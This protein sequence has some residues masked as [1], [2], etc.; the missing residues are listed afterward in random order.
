MAKVDIEIQPDWVENIEAKLQ[1]ALDRM[2]KAIR[3]NARAKAPMSE[4]YYG[5]PGGNLRNSGRVT[6]N[7]NIRLIS[8]GGD[9]VPYGKAQEFG[10]NGKVVFRHYTTPGTGK[11]YLSSSARAALQKGF[12]AYL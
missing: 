2:A 6:G 7:G 1:P 9:G 10:T 4:D 12:K 8:F 5:E 11:N 3:A